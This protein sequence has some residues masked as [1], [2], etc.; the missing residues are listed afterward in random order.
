MVFSWELRH[1]IDKHWLWD[2]CSCY[3]AKDISLHAFD[4]EN[5]KHM[6]LQHFVANVYALKHTCTRTITFT[7]H[8][9]G[10]S[11]PWWLSLRFIVYQMQHS[12]A[13]HMHDAHTLAN[14]H[15][16]FAHHWMPHWHC[17]QCEQKGKNVPK[18]TQWLERAVQQFYYWNYFYPQLA[19]SM[20]VSLC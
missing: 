20:C 6:K 10:K 11:S 5:R 3:G 17:V 15:A 18:K 12:F 7:T 13:L 2:Q 4:V 1:T 16:Q 19:L 8:K 9:Y 14:W